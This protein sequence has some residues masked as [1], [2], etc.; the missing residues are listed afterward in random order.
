VKLS[1]DDRELFYEVLAHAQSDLTS[2][3]S[4]IVVLHGWSGRD[5][6]YLRPALDPLAR[7]AKTVFC[8]HSPDGA[9]V[10]ELDALRAQLGHETITLLGHGHG[11]LLAQGYALERPEHVDRLILC[12]SLPFPSQDLSQ[13]DA[14]ALVI[15]G[16]HDPWAKPDVTRAVFDMIP[17]AEMFLFENSG[18]FPF[19]SQPEA[20]FEIVGGWIEDRLPPVEDWSP[21]SLN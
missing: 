9:I 20:F 18:H 13:L 2:I 10:E 8:D 17:A 3:R 12:G 14:P 15:G 16:R 5:G 19:V 1:L 4:P 7:F 21:A 11:G 6:S